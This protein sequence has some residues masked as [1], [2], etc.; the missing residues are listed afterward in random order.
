MQDAQHREHG[1]QVAGGRLLHREEPVRA[2]LDVVVEVVDLA[3]VGDDLVDEREVGVE[4]GVGAGADRLGHEGREPDDVAAQVVERVLEPV[5]PSRL[6]RRHPVLLSVADPAAD[7]FVAAL[8]SCV[9]RRRC[10]C[11]TTDSR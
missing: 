3:V 7:S 9:V 8:Q 4:Q 2:E 6:G 10:A 1:P 5:A 11:V